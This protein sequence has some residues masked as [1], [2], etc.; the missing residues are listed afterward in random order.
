MEFNPAEVGIINRYIEKS[1]IF[2][3]PISPTQVFLVEDKI[4][5]QAVV[6]KIIRK[7][8]LLNAQ[9]FKL[10]KQE[11]EIHSLMNHS[12]IVKLF[13]YCETESDFHLYLEY[14]DKSSYL[15]NKILDEHTPIGKKDKLI[16]YIQDILE[17]LSYIHRQGVIHEDIK[18]ENILMKSPE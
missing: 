5:K 17:G 2:A 18:L 9:A 13:N 10:A 1:L 15:A 8:R 14:C 12:N 16:S 11:C 6:K 3:E 7:D 4:D